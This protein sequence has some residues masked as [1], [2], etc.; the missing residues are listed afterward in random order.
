[1]STEVHYIAGYGSLIC[2]ESRSRTGIGSP[3]VPIEI[4]GIARRWSVPTPEWQATAVGAHVDDNAT[5]SAIY[6]EVDAENLKRFDAREQ[7]YQRR[8]IPWEQVTIAADHG[9]TTEL[10]KKG[11]LWIYVGD[12]A[13]KP[14]KERPIMQSYLDVILNGCLAISESFAERFMLTTQHWQQLV[15]D[16][17]NPQYP[18]ALNKKADTERFDAVIQNTLPEL[19]GQRKLF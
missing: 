6:F 13:H 14:S 1:M 4:E 18:R 16:R 3:A 2:A 17:A 9:N 10:P 5:T 7:G 11:N 19:Y 15:D 8:L 12:S